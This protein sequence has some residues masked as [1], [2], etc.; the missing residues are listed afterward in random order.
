MPL[1]HLWRSGR[2]RPFKPGPTSP[3]FGRGCEFRVTPQTASPVRLHDRTRGQPGWLESQLADEQRFMRRPRSRSPAAARARALWPQPP[4]QRRSCVPSLPHAARPSL[5]R[6]MDP[7]WT[8][9]RYRLSAA[10]CAKPPRLRRFREVGATGFDQRPFGPQPDGNTR[11]SVLPHLHPPR[12]PCRWVR[13]VVVRRRRYL[14]RYYLARASGSPASPAY[15]DHRCRRHSRR[16]R[17]GGGWDYY[18]RRGHGGVRKAERGA[19]HPLQRAEGPNRA[20]PLPGR[21]AARL[22][23]PSCGQSSRGRC[24]TRTSA[25]GYPDA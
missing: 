1:L 11:P 16:S 20:A 15:T 25:A 23:P 9:P 22:A 18:D 10:R 4:F 3:P 19:A 7:R 14:G 17:L 5:S 13:W 6:E 2:I 12:P 21:G 8:P 24:P